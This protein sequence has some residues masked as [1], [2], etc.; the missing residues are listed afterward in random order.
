[1]KAD[2][3][4][5]RLLELKQEFQKLKQEMTAPD[6]TDTSAVEPSVPEAVA[7]EP[8]KAELNALLAQEH[9]IQAARRRLAANFAP[10]P[11]LLCPTTSSQHVV[12]GAKRDDKYPSDKPPDEPKQPP[13]APVGDPDMTALVNRSTMAKADSVAVQEDRDH[14]FELEDHRHN[15][16]SVVFELIPLFETCRLHE[17]THQDESSINYCFDEISENPSG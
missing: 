3:E 14:I 2:S 7:D 12:T 11:A 8:T 6:V 16:F 15:S 5:E 4:F 13:K 9:A 17:I 1:M 10:N